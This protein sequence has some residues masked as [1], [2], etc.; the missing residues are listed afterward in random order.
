MPNVIRKYSSSNVIPHESTFCKRNRKESVWTCIYTMH[1]YYI[2]TLE[3]INH[4]KKKKIPLLMSIGHYNRNFAMLSFI[5]GLWSSF[6]QRNTISFIR[7][8]YCIRRV[9]YLHDRETLDEF[10]C[11]YIII[12][13]YLVSPSV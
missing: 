5:C 7:S 2:Y 11:Y 6:P 12:I 13:F 8:N 10:V 3:K 4:Q 1:V 9:E